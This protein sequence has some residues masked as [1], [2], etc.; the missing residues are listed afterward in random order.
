M[1]SIMVYCEGK[2][3]PVTSRKKCI[4]A[5]SYAGYAKDPCKI[6]RC[7]QRTRVCKG[8]GK[9]SKWVS[10]CSRKKKSTNY[11]KS[12]YTIRKGKRGGSRIILV[13]LKYVRGRLRKYTR[14]NGKM[15]PLRKGTKT[16]KTKRSATAA[17]KRSRK[18]KSRRRS[19][20]FGSTRPLSFPLSGPPPDP[21][22]GSWF[23]P[24]CD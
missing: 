4:A 6:V 13:Y 17:A 18:K 8:V 22:S 3:F 12:G 16:Y 7:V 19:S 20:R 23:F 5:L 14:K 11:K 15:I 21:L 24:F 2:K 9:T 10:R 1:Y